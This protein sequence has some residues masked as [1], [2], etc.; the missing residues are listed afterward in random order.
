MTWIYK[1][2]SLS[3]FAGYPCT[4][5]AVGPAWVCEGLPQEPRGTLASAGEEESGD[6]YLCHSPR[7]EGSAE[8]YLRLLTAKSLSRKPESPEE[9]SEKIIDNESIINNTRQPW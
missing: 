8:D 3:N 4:R 1:T 6:G 5:I 7:A 9:K 2:G